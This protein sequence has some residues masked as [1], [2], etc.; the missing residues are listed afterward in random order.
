MPESDTEPPEFGNKLETAIAAKYVLTGSR[1]YPKVPSDFPYWLDKV[2][3]LKENT[4]KIYK[5]DVAQFLGHIENETSRP[6]VLE[7][8]W[9][10]NLTIKYFKKIA[11]TFKPNTRTNHHSALSALRAYLRSKK[12]R[13]SNY[14]D[15]IEDFK[16]L[17]RGASKSKRS[18][19]AVLLRTKSK[20]R[21]LLGEFY[22]NIYH[23]NA[24]W[25]RYNKEIKK[26]KSLVRHQRKVDP[27]PRKQFNFCTAFML[28]ILLAPN[29]KRTGNFG[30]IPFEEPRKLLHDSLSAFRR[31][32]PS[33][34]IG[35]LPRRLDVTKCI[36]AVFDVS[37]SAKKG[38]IESFCVLQARDQK[39]LLEYGEY[40]RPNGPRPPVSETFFLDSKGRA[41]SS[42]KIHNLLKALGESTLVKDLTISSLRTLVETEN[43]LRPES[44]ALTKQLGHS[45][46]TAL[47]YYVKEDRR[48]YVE[49][50]LAI[51]A[52]L[53]QEGEKPLEEAPKTLWDPV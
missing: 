31:K 7:D 37:D 22:R 23:N 21:R 6:G 2:K 39:G 27:I 17:T 36:P 18:Y 1:S 41:L 11:T 24:C 51:M 15:L 34:R 4:I 48:H 30:I 12:R 28:A 38:E 52:I 53:E 25:D 16:M 10:L 19:Q 44:N 8:A 13:P 35:D 29:L 45:V 47:E 33:T 9:N 14:R 32:F 5:H 20:D 26:I 42:D 50:S 40:V 46:A 3:H 49:A 43:F